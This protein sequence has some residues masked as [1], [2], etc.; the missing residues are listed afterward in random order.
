MN[1]SNTARA[2]TIA[3]DTP[4]RQHVLQ[5]PSLE[6]DQ[7]HRDGNEPGRGRSAQYARGTAA[8]QRE[9]GRGNRQ[10]RAG[11]HGQPARECLDGHHDR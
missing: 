9:P 8:E 5:E 10:Q 4:A 1:A 6:Y 7:E 11:K 2:A 3:T